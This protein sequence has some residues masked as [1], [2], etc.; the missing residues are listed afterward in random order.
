MPAAAF[1]IVVMGLLAAA[2][3]RI[4]SQTS[5][6]TVQEQVSIQA[7]YAAESGAQFAMTRLFFDAT[8]AVTRT[9]AGT[10]CASLTGSSLS[11]N[12]TGM[13]N[14]QVD[15]SC[16]E[17]ADPAN[18]V[19]FFHIDAAANCGSSPLNASRHVRVSAQ[20]R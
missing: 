6:A 2:M 7:F 10:Q 12:T 1:I 9:T 11:L 4:G 20:L 13:Q 8:G 14:C 5:V 19:S 17:S 3:G 18:T 16:Q 15:L